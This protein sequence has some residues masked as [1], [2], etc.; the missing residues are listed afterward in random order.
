MGAETEQ[1]L[2]PTGNLWFPGKTIYPASARA[3]EIAKSREELIG[4]LRGVPESDYELSLT[5]LVEKRSEQDNPQVKDK[6]CGAEE[7]KEKNHKA[8]KRNGSGKSSS[9]GGGGGSM[10]RN[11]SG[12]G[13]VLLKVFVPVSLTRRLT[14]SSSSVSVRTPLDSSNRDRE[15]EAMPGCCWWDRGRGSGKSWRHSFKGV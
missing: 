1:P 9:G 7:A 2:S 6:N 5:D 12:N 14:R 13:G 15:E 11:G 4:L 10:G 8:N 3:Q